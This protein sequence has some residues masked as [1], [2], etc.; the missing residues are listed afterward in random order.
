MTKYPMAG[1][2]QAK[3]VSQLVSNPAALKRNHR[4][5]LGEE[6][7]RL[8][9][10]PDPQSMKVIED[11]FLEET[12]TDGLGPT[13]TDISGGRG[14]PKGTFDVG[15]FDYVDEK[16]IH[17][18]VSSMAG[19]RER[20]KMVQWGIHSVT[21]YFN[22]YD[23]TMSIA[24]GT[25]RL[26]RE[27]HV[28]GQFMWARTV[29]ASDAWAV[30][31][32]LKTIPL[33]T[34]EV[35]LEKLVDKTLDQDNSEPEEIFRGR[36]DPVVEQPYERSTIYRPVG[37]EAKGGHA[38]SVGTI[39]IRGRGVRDPDD[40][41]NL[42]DNPP[43]LT[44]AI[45]DSYESLE[46]KVDPKWLPRLDAV[47]ATKG[48]LTA[49]VKEYGCGAY[50][51][52]IPT[53]DP[54]VVLKATIDTTETEFARDLAG[55]LNTPICTKYHQVASIPAKHHNR[56]VY[57]LWREAAEEVGKVSGDALEAIN[58]QHDCANAA[59]TVIHD[60]HG[61]AEGELAAWLEA[62]RAM[63]RVPELAFVANGM[64][65]AFT[66]QGVFIGDVHGG[67]L[68]KCKRN[69]KMEWVITDPGHVAV[70]GG[71]VDTEATRAK[72]KRKN[73]ARSADENA[74]LFWRLLTLDR[75]PASVEVVR[76]LVEETNL[77]LVELGE[78]LS[79]EETGALTP[80]LPHQ[81][82]ARVRMSE[83]IMRGLGYDEA[84]WAIDHHN[85]YTM[86]P[87]SLLIRIS[88]AQIWST[89]NSTAGEVQV[90]FNKNVTLDEAREIGA[91]AC[92]DI[93]C[94]MKLHPEMNGEEV[95][96]L[97]WGAQDHAAA[98]RGEAFLAHRPDDTW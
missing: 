89:A 81:K 16:G 73:P 70:I 45:A 96:D 61:T 83:G 27:Y 34:S 78:A 44:K 92:F 91:R 54:D 24:N 18:D 8:M 41:D 47:K 40:D 43:W 52:V 56:R 77:S 42:I 88:R 59:Y 35:K 26:K 33:T 32:A 57:L 95:L 49:R 74:K 21:G 2:L 3:T 36:R 85:A 63:A 68:G 9:R 82:Q 53:L 62:V 38:S 58:R 84:E 75:S 67:N 23:I 11:M 29:A 22:Q 12:Q 25:A 31:K 14:S 20:W 87:L 13:L 60:E 50:G 30:A 86:H 66:K 5:N 37:I 10:D 51:C 71:K 80:P 17:H 69:G 93:V 28:Q 90:E 15:T 79:E 55:K 6:F 19:P 39:G 97:W 65:E 4:N 7:A 48:R 94:E 46:R 98:L 72:T 76:D 64:A 1:D